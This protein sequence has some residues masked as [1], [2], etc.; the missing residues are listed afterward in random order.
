MRHL[1]LFVC[2][3][4]LTIFGTCTVRGEETRDQAPAPA[5]AAESATNAGEQS[6]P[7]AAAAKPVIERSKREICDTL[8]QSAQSN[9]LPIPF[10]IRLLLQESGFRSDV[11]SRAGAQGIAQFVPETARS[12]GLDNPFDPLQAIAASA[13]LLRNLVTKFGNLGLA[14]AAYNAGPRRISNWLVRKSKLPQETQHYV[15]ITGT[16]GGNVEG[17]T[18]ADCRTE[19]HAPCRDDAGVIASETPSAPQIEARS[20]VLARSSAKETSRT[21][22]AQASANPARTSLARLAKRHKGGK[23]AVQLA[24]ASKK[25]RHKAQS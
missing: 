9:A 20:R 6:V 14:A 21:T 22:V 1:P 5:A 10:F 13:R 11:V 16:S 8:V 18:G 25:S 12:V 3:C 24:A 4:S 15:K 19:K 7:P 23:G 17:Q 2:L